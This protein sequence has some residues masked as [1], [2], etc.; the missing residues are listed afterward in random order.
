MKKMLLNTIILLFVSL[1]SFNTAKSQNA[2]DVN[3][4]LKRTIDLHAMQQYYTDSEKEGLTPLIIINDD[5]IPDNLILFKFNKRVKVLTFDEI[6]TLKQVYK[7]NLD[8]YFQIKLFKL[9][10]GKAEVDGTFR[11]EQPIKFHIVM[12]KKNDNWIVDQSKVTPS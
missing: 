8:S 6:K 1:F 3:L 2:R 5:N 7:G 11:K 10:D 4:I 9:P 12:E